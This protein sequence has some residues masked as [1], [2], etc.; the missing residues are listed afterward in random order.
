MKRLLRKI[1]PRS[2]F[3]KVK[4]VWRE[5]RYHFNVLKVRV[6]IMLGLP[7]KK[8]RD[9]L[10]FEVHIA[11][12]CNL[13]C[14]SCNNFSCIA[15][16]E[17]VDVEEFRRDMSRLSDIF[18][19]RL[20]HMY[21]IGGEP[22]LNPDIITLM[23]IARSS[24]TDGGIGIFTNGIL[25]PKMSD[26][27]WRACH[28]YDIGITVSEYPIKLDIDTIK[29]KARHFGVSFHYSQ[30]RE[31]FYVEPINLKG[32]SDIKL[33]FGLC[34]RAN[35]CVALSHG[36]LFTCTFAPNV[37]HLNHKFGT[38]I[39]ITPAD[40]IDIYGSVSADE[41]LDFLA[42]P[43]PACRYCNMKNSVVRPIDWGITNGRLEEW[44]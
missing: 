43:I 29:E 8:K 34:V 9:K 33:N 25:L 19:G 13:N 24:F 27:F 38:D 14:A 10:Y 3:R 41:I 44:T 11:E 12:H 18:G 22:L 35:A 21:L 37:H 40:Y 42:R 30:T 5:A 31:T 2:L 28:D 7:L 23:K 16:P 26:E 32:S 20:G 6:K 1:L 4:S 15:E 17:F 36:R 39:E